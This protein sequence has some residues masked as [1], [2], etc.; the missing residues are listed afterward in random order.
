MSWV[1]EGARLIESWERPDPINGITPA[2]M[3]VV[4]SAEIG[5]PRHPLPE[6]AKRYTEDVTW[7]D[8]APA[9]FETNFI[10]MYA[11]PGGPEPAENNRLVDR[12]ELPNGE[13]V[14]VL[15]Q[16]HA[17]SEAAKQQ[18]QAARQAMSEW[19]A[20]A[21]SVDRENLEA[22]LEPRG[23]LYGH[24]ELGTRFFVD[25]SADFLFE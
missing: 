1:G 17:I 12:F 4:P 15:I 10:V 9:G 22:A 11:D 24:N 20:H 7:V 23:Y 14:F 21:Q 19:V 25:I 5:L 8:P 16:E 6:R 13:T 18:L 2:F 3:I